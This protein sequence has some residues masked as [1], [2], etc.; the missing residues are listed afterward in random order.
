MIISAETLDKMY[1]KE[2][3]T[4]AKMIVKLPARDHLVPTCTHW[5][6][7]FHNA[8][9]EVKFER[10]WMLLQLHTQ[11]N[12]KS[13]IGYP[14][15]DPTSFH[16]DLRALM[17]RSEQMRESNDVDDDNGES[18][19]SAEK[20]T[21]SMSELESDL[22]ERNQQLLKE[23][24]ALRSE[25]KKLQ[26]LEDE[27]QQRKQKLKKMEMETRDS[28]EDMQILASS[29]TMALK[30]LST[31]EDANAKSQFFK[32]LFS[33]LG[34]DEKDLAQVEKLDTM[35]DTLLRDSINGY[36]QKQRDLVVQEVS[37]KYDNVVA[38]F[39]EH[40]GK[41]MEGKLVAQEKELAQSALRYLEVLRKHFVWKYMGNDSTKEAVLKFL[42]RSCQQMS[43][44]L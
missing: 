27:L 6:N 5:L 24:D 19:A 35:F 14:F 16:M 1:V 37:L 2:V 39:I 23:S 7:I 25:L 41:V 34:Q 8:A 28:G 15:T 9:P 29:A 26:G 3:I 22:H 11:L 38:D 31:K 10:N 30:L 32:T 17:Q 43:E 33:P 36:K 40:Y 42:K 20:S 12:R 44:I 21:I 13:N 18:W 4:V